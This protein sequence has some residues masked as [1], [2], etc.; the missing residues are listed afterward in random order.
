MFYFTILAVFPSLPTLWHSVVFYE[1]CGMVCVH[2]VERYNI[3]PLYNSKFEQLYFKIQC[4][5][6]PKT[7]ENITLILN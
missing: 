6:V 3:H 5:I 7:T 4:R 1:I 2:T